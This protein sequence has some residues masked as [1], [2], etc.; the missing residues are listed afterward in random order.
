MTYAKHPSG[1]MMPVQGP[2]EDCVKAPV[3]SEATRAIIDRGG[4]I[5]LPFDAGD[6]QIAFASRWELARMIEA[7]ILEARIDE[8]AR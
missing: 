4:G 3:V 5:L 2:P 6:A 8:L 1:L 7:A